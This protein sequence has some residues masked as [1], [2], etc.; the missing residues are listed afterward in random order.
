MLNKLAQEIHENAVNHG[1]YDEPRTFGE[2]MVLCHSEISEAVEEYRAGHS[3][4][5]IRRDV[6]GKP[7]GVPIELAD[8][9]IRLLDACGYYDI[10]IEKAVR[11]KHEYNKSRSYRHGGK[12]I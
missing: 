6:S 4:R 7:E 9:I 5:E 1:W 11:D 10:D 3:V 2:I 12:V 8:T